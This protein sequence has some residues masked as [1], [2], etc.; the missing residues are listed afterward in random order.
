MHK[1]QDIEE[2]CLVCQKL[3]AALYRYRVCATDEDIFSNRTVRVD[4]MN[5]FGDNVLDIV[6]GDTKS[7]AAAFL[8]VQTIHAVWFTY[9]N[10][11]PLTCIGRPEHV[12]WDQESKFQS[13]SRGDFCHISGTELTLSE[14][15][16]HNSLAEGKRCHKYFRSIYTEVRSNFTSMEKDCAL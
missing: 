6:H 1:P 14:I 16:G 9:K 2:A 4:V 8:P 13:Q 5:I 10:T 3:S 12:Q 15:E 11:W 7:N